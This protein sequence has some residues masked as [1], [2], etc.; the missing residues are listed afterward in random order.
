MIHTRAFKVLAEEE[1]VLILLI[2]VSPYG[3]SVRLCNRSNECTFET[4]SCASS[5]AEINY[6]H[7]KKVS[8]ALVYGVKNIISICLS[9][10]SQ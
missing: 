8:F 5:N 2:D 9:V 3:V 6:S 7:L 10:H 4:V 1:V